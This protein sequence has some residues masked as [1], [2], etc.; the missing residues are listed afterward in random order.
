LLGQ[1]NKTF[2]LIR[3][4]LGYGLPGAIFLAIGVIAKNGDCKDCGGFSLAGA[5]KIL[6]A[7][8]FDI[9][10]WALCL[11]LLAFCYAAGNVLAAV[12]YM[13]FGLA[14]YIVWMIFRHFGKRRVINKS[15]S[16]VAIGQIK[17]AVG[18]SAQ[19]SAVHFGSL[20]EGVVLAAEV[21]NT[22]AAEVPIGDTK[23]AAGKTNYVTEIQA[24][25][26]PQGVVVIEPAPREGSWLDWLT[27]HATEVN[28]RTLEIRAQ[29]SD[30]LKTLDRR[31]TLNVMG[32][33]MAAALLGGYL[34]FYRWHWGLPDVILWGGL[35]ALVQFLTG[36]SHVRRVLH[37]VHVAN[38]ASPQPDP[39]LAKLLGE[40]IAA[41]TAALKKCSGT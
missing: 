5:Q 28:A 25:S 37:A 1:L 41:A 8:P 27:N 32:G 14:K 12:I 18:E 38:V 31:E 10:P 34:V 6:A 15:K 9:P 4:V 29:N 35:I 39:D 26:L 20:P 19:V 3:D 13:P 30:L 2:D 7:V 24:Q 36:L 11:G 33:S 21:L 40:L 23:I 22:T 16:E 17:I